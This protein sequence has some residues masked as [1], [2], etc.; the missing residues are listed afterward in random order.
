MDPLEHLELQDPKVTLDLV[1]CQERLD[2]L[3]LRE[4]PVSLGPRGWLVLVAL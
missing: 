4:H 2:N 1:V 3:D